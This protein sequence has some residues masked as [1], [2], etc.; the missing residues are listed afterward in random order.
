M[1]QH[2]KLFRVR[3]LADNDED[4]ILTLAETFVEEVSEDVERLKAAVAK[5]DY[6]N[7]YQAAHKMKPTIDLFELGIL[8]DLIE[9][10]D[11]GK[12]QKTEM[13]ISDKLHIVT[14]AVDHALAEIKSDFNL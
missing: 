10:Q 9:V 8:D 11:W 4:F 7:A 2:Y 14:T 12:F 1:E 13:D 5:K 6:H 3:E